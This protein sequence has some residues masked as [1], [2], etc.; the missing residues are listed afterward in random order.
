MDSVEKR[1]RGVPQ[2]Q[3]RH[4]KILVKAKNLQDPEK[5]V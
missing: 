3:D 4:S 1:E 5:P 2:A